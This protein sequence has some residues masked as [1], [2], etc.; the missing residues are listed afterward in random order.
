MSEKYLDAA[1]SPRERAEDLLAKLSLEEKMGQINCLFPWQ[2]AIDVT[3]ENCPHG[4]GQVSTLFLRSLET[5]EEAAAWQKKYQRMV[6]ERSE[7]HIPAVFHMEG[8]CGAFLNGATSFPSGIGRG[9]SFDPELERQIGEIVSRQEAACGITQILAPVLDISRDSRMGRQ[10]ETYGEDP[11]LAAAM[12]A[13]YVK[14]IQTG[15]T[16][17]RHA[18]SEAKH[19]LGFH[20]S[21]AGIHGASVEMGERQLKEVYAKP[22]QAAITESSLRG[23]MPC[24]CSINGEPVSSSKKFLTDWLRGD[25]GFD[26]VVGADYSAVYN[27]HHAQHVAADTTEA[28]RMCLEAGLDVEQ[29]NCICYNDGLKEL[30]AA[31]KADMAVLDRAVL[32]VLEAKFRMGLFEHPFALEGE[33]L[34]RVFFR[35]EDRAVTLR[36][37]L[38][39][40]VLL[41]NNGVLPL[42]KGLGKIA[43]VG[44]QAKNA[45]IFF[46]GY[47]HVSMEEGDRASANSMAGLKTGSLEGKEILRVPG[48]QIQSDETEQF[49][50]VL[51][52]QKPEC[53][54]L[55]EQLRQDFPETEV[56]YAY[57]YTVAGDDLSRL[58]EALE[59]CKGADVILLTLGGKH[60]SC[61]VASMG[62][63]VDGT[64]INLPVCQETFIKRAAE[65]GIPMVGIHFN[66]RPVSSDAADLY[67]DAILEAW[68]PSEMGAP[69]ISAVLRGEYNPSG[70]L[71]V[72][73]ARNAGQIPVFYN[74]AAG[75]SWH[76]GESIGFA[77][78]VDL[79]HRPR[80]YFGY[81][82]SY[83]TFAYSNLTLDKRE[84]GPEEEIRVCFDLTNTGDREGTEVP[85]LYLHDVYASCS[86][87]VKELAGF[88][89]IT[90]K[91]GE[92]KRV[93]F[94]LQ[95][96]Q[97]A[98]VDRDM[99]WK[100]E[101]GE[102]ELMVG[103]SSEDIWL[104][105][106]FTVRE[107]G[108]VD[109]RTRGFY[110]KCVEG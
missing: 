10:G 101:K 47:T 40:M 71:P 102:I 55:L 57:G 78:Y 50:S 11:A 14:G 52:L 3:P 18:E 106:S 84:A 99:R 22:F 7:H 110:A 1:L 6:M 82:L 83:T 104:K 37:A 59:V 87:P 33:E 30:F 46:G 85:Q 100:V 4:I 93:S 74:H 42:K 73:V 75:S 109:E 68:N 34:R 27:V 32:R 98:F 103:S 69:A 51:R 79:P 89:R 105:D 29:Q 17:G 97:A 60:G 81:G 38:E 25:M 66:G 91:S 90:L 44:A 13:A 16:A 39:S 53:K 67:L 64:D 96:S 70:R 65:L 62:E 15:E 95:V 76:Q 58:E 21:L 20:A 54:S 12:G 56:A 61:S 88:G 72:T 31:G 35:E 80:Y 26:G 41:K 28:G 108:Y 94:L 2:E 107:D 77:D 45:R 24:Y 48:T 9:S 23:I 19:F 36:S 8:L 92:K 49:D 5:L 86:R 43:V 63:G